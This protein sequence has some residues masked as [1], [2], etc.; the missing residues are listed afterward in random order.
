M[1]RRAFLKQSAMPA[2]TMA[3]AR[4]SFGQAAAPPKPTLPLAPAKG[5]PFDNGTFEV[6]VE[7]KDCPEPRADLPPEALVQITRRPER[8]R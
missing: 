4:A 8:R 5:T 3:A 2:A 1:D 6:V 7:A